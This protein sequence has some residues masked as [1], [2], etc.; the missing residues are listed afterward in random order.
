M[1]IHKTVQHSVLSALRILH[2]YHLNQSQY[3]PILMSAVRSLYIN[4]KKKLK[5]TFSVNQ[6]TIDPLWSESGHHM[7]NFISFH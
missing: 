5:H 3:V 6:P 4:D 7:F 1:S 2:F